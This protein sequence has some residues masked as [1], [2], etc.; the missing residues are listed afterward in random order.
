VPGDRERRF[1]LDDLVEAARKPFRAIDLGK[2]ASRL[3]S[4][5]ARD[6]LSMR[7]ASLSPAIAN[8]VSVLRPA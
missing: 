6:T 1:S 2:A 8:A 4:S 7:V 3:G 5:V